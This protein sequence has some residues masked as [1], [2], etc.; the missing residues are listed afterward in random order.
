MNKK[1]DILF[2]MNNLNVG[3][4]EKS[5][6]SFLRE[7]DYDKYEVDLLL[8]KKEGRLLNQ[9]PDQVNLLQSPE[10]FKYFDS[11]FKKTTVANLKKGNLSLIFDRIQFSRLQKENI[12]RAVKEQRGWKFIKKH[13]QKLEK[14]YD[15]AIGFLEKTPNYFVVDC[16]N[17]N[18][19]IGFVR[20]DYNK[21]GMDEKI[22][23]DYFAK[24][25]YICTNSENATNTLQQKFPKIADKIVT[26]ENI[27][28]IVTIR[29]LADEKIEIDKAE[30]NIVSVGRLTESKNFEVAI[31]SCKQLIDAGYTVKWLLVGEGNRRSILEN[32]I[33]NLGLQ[34][35]FILMGEKDNPYPYLKFADI[36]VHPSVFEGKT[37]SVEEAKILGKYIVVNNYPSASEQIVHGETGLITENSPESIAKAILEIHKNEKLRKILDRNLEGIN[38]Q[39]QTVELYKYL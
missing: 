32:K 18:K 38:S 22:D 29:D 25:D 23:Q 17:A 6:I 34:D 4:A 2:V 1:K 5:L 27:F 37:R 21:M 9:I 12:N 11:S 36:F 15:T 39:N 8:L 19:K 20:T 35:F 13:M 16:V 26:I 3:G 10:N 31:D 14:Q 28:P 24:L 30:I 33:E 7:F